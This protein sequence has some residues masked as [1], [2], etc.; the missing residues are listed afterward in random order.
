MARRS[1]PA[2]L[3]RTRFETVVKAVASD[4]SFSV[5]S[6]LTYPGAD[7]AGDEVVADGLDFTPHQRNPRVDL[8]HG[9]HPDVG[10]QT[11]GWAHT[12]L[13]RPGGT[14]TVTKSLLDVPNHG[15]QLLPVATTHFDRDD[16]LQRQVYLMVRKGALP[17]VSLEFEPDWSK[18]IALGD[19]PIERRKAFRFGA[20][21]VRL[22]T[23]CAEPVCQGAQTILKSLP[24][25][26]EPLLKVLRDGTIEG[27]RLHPH[28]LKSLARYTP[29]KTVVAVSGAEVPSSIAKS[30]QPFHGPYSQDSCPEC[31]EAA[32]ATCRCIRND[33]W[34]KNGHTWE[35]L[36]DGTPVLLDG[37]HGKVIKSYSGDTL[38]QA[39]AK[40]KSFS[41]FFGN[42]AMPQPQDQTATKYDPTPTDDPNAMGDD[43]TGQDA[44]GPALGGIS[45]LYSAAQGAVGIAD[46]L[47]SDMQTSDSPQLRK[48][49]REAKQKILAFAQE[50][51]GMADKHHATL[52][53]D[54]GEMGDDFE[55]DDSEDGDDSEL[56]ETGADDTDTE[57]DEKPPVK[58]KKPKK[59]T[60]MSRDDE[61]TLKA[62]PP[63]YREVL[64][65]VAPRRYSLREVTDGIEAA[66][67]QAI[68]AAQATK[69]ATPV[70]TP[71]PE[72]EDAELQELLADVSKARRHLKQTRRNYT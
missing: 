23:I 33:R 69:K 66:Q 3:H 52:D 53:S 51:K 25:Q 58:K 57:G 20:A 29:S 41:K 47:E 54:G 38:E 7:R 13:G 68:A 46:Q 5:V 61:G 35:R 14:Y 18:A 67:Q 70:V 31:G 43:A 34:C 64:K 40:R 49:G 28:I 36:T 62:V 11:V 19:S 50:M 56:E 21:K 45:A 42:K 26:L 12:K 63:Q 48:F 10:R 59:P 15:K 72:E 8:E 27:E 2:Q 71:E 60:D 9:L 32:K 22:Y 37:G 39:E 30:H 24:P 17:A 1:T 6:V 16:P 55:D 44:S 65:A 4:D